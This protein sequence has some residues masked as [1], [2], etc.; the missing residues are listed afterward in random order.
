MSNKTIGQFNTDVALTGS[1]FIL[2]MSE[3]VT[4]KLVLDSV[5]NFI[6]SGSSSGSTSVEITGGTYN[7]S[8]GALY[9]INS[10]GGTITITGFYTGGTFVE[11]ISDDGNGIVSVDN[12]NPINPIIIFSGLNIDNSTIT[13]TGLSGAP[14]TVIS[15]PLVLIGDYV[16]DAAAD[17]DSNLPSGGL[18]T[19]SGSTGR[20]VY[21][22][23]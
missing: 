20:T 11:S 10:T 12:T 6:L 17:A 9:L 1:E 8:S 3:N 15:S 16:D 13:G 2:G 18:Y 4:V 14:L 21:R 23:P 19:T 7:N 5:K 22:K